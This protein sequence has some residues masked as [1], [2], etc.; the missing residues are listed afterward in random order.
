MKLAAPRIHEFENPTSRLGRCT[1]VVVV[2]AL[3]P[4]DGFVHTRASIDE[5]RDE[6][7]PTLEAVPGGLALL[8]QLL[9]QFGIRIEIVSHNESDAKA[10]ANDPCDM[11]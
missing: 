3:E 7:L 9:R 2:Q 4:S 1:A 5:I 11:P 8:V 10:E 6:L